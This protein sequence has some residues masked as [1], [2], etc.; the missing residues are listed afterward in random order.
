MLFTQQNNTIEYKDEQISQTYHKISN[1]DDAEN[2]ESNLNLY[3]DAYKYDYGYS[4]ILSFSGE[5][6]L[7]DTYLNG[8]NNN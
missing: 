3:K 7:M 8:I 6:G 1:N 4:I 2:L 5:D